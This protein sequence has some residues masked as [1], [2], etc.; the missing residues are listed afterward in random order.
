MFQYKIGD[1]T[2]VTL[3]VTE[4]YSSRQP[5]DCSKN[6]K[7]TSLASGLYP[8]NKGQSP[9]WEANSTLGYSGNTQPFIETESS[10]TCQQP[11]I[12]DWIQFISKYNLEAVDSN[13][14]P[15]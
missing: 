14:I 12:T 7:A 6:S 8:N 4:P 5:F 13:V 9:S 11:Q 1:K 15:L 3:Q 2:R 10:L